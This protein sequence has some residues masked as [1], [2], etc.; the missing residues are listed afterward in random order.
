MDKGGFLSRNPVNSDA[1]VPT[2]PSTAPDAVGAAV[3]VLAAREAPEAEETRGDFYARL[4][5]AEE[6]AHRS[7]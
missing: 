6:P 5:V 3:A 2:A 4:T 1:A 7:I